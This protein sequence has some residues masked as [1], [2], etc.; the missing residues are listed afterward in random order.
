[1]TTKQPEDWTYIAL[2]SPIDFWAYGLSLS[3]FKTEFIEQISAGECEIEGYRSFLIMKEKIDKLIN[4]YIKKAER[5][6]KT[7]L[8]HEPYIIAL[9]GGNG[10]WISIG[11]CFKLDNNGD[12]VLV[13]KTRF[14]K[15]MEE[16]LRVTNSGYEI[17]RLIS[18]VQI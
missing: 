6:G 18:N 3:G 2:D 9:P 5:Y 12:T 14:L 11:Y 16:W 7:F 8:R 1:M 4:I 13:I 15:L 10:E 17:S